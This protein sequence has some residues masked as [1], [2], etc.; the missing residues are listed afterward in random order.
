MRS[1]P[2]ILALAAIVLGGG[3]L[4]AQQSLV[5]FQGQVLL[6]SGAN[7][8]TNG[9]LAPGLP[10]GERFGG[11]SGPDNGVIAD[12]GS[13]LFRAQVVDSLGV[14]YPTAQ[15]YLGRA[16][17]YGDSR[18]NLVKV[19]RGGDP[20]P[21][22]TIPGAT[23]QSSTGGV[24]FTGSPRI[25]ANGLMMFGATV[26]DVA[27]GTVTTAN[28]TVLYVGT[29]GNFQILAREGDVAPNTGGATYSSAFSGMSQQPTCLNSSGLALF[30]SSLAG[31]GVVTANNAAWFTGAPGNVQLMLRKGDL[32]PGGEQVSA[33]GSVSQMNALGQVVTDVTYLAG[34]GT[35]PVTT[36][37]DKAIWLYTPGLG[38]AQIVRE[39]DASP[40]PGTYF[41]N[42]GSTWGVS[43]GSTTFNAS[44]QLM[45]MTDL[46]GLVSAGIDDR[47][48]VLVSAGGHSV[49]VRRGDPAPGVP[50]ANFDAIHGS[51]QFLA[52][53]GRVA[54]QSTL[55]NGGVTAANDSGIWTG[56][57]GG[58]V[59]VMREGD[60]APGTGGQTFGTPLGFFMLMNGSG[61]ILF[62]NTLSGGSSSLWSW[63]PVIGLQLVVMNGDQIEVQPGVFKSAT[64]TGG[65]QFTNGSTRPLSFAN[66]GTATFRLS[67]TDGSCVVSVRVGSLTGLP[68]KISQ[69]TGGAHSLYLDAGAAH[70]NQ[71]YVVAGS[72]SGTSPG[73]PIG[74]FVVPL[75]LDFYTDYTIQ[76]A[77]VP[78]FVN[79]FNALNA[80]GRALAQVVIPPAVPGITGVVVHHA[81][82]V[83]DAF[84]NL[85]FASEAARLEI[86]P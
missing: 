29:P 61:Q 6:Y 75:N 16:Y 52:D 68:G 59:L 57:P 27:G 39:G 41:A 48:L 25:S 84:N 49:V 72:A 60:V 10:G 46:T 81:Y 40:I 23:L 74:L 51:N 32:G 82:V 17:Y 2:V 12:D 20:E 18:G 63:D 67:L 71:T 3:I 73:V 83:L 56:M 31:T 14:A 65:V 1:Y 15:A 9:D 45:I 69:A 4:A 19:L 44:G 11:N 24:A 58:L 76:S 78:P 13:V 42:V 54:I 36:A 22:G 70:A 8:T 43:T 34:S 38:N 86:T 66:D 77:N 53:D 35:T 7:N 28:D 80:E 47:A 30:Q 62:N 50:G 37:N 85:V 79:T 33:L 26:W 64:S 5:Q 55:V 21:S